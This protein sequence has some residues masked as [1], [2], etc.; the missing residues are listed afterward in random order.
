[1]KGHFPISLQ[2]DIFNQMMLFHY[3]IDGTDNLDIK[4]TTNDFIW[5]KESCQ[6]I[7]VNF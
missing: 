2:H 5:A 7:L 3:H 1:M 4:A 6:H